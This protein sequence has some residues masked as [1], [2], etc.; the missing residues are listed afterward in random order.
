VQPGVGHPLLVRS[1]GREIPDEHIRNRQDPFGAMGG[2]WMITATHPVLYLVKPHRACHSILPTEDALSPQDRAH[3]H[4]PV[5]LAA[6]LMSF[7]DL[8]QQKRIGCAPSAW[9]SLMSRIAAAPRYPQHLAHWSDL[10]HLLIRFHELL[11]LLP[12]FGKMVMAFFRIS[13]FWVTT[14]RSRLTCLSFACTAARP[15]GSR[16][17]LSEATLYHFRH[18]SSSPVMLPGSRVSSEAFFP[19]LSSKHSASSLNPR[20]HVRYFRVP[21]WTS[22]V[23]CAPFSDIF[24]VHFFVSFRDLCRRKGMK[25]TTGKPTE[26]R[27]PIQMN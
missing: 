23:Q 20:I 13:C 10:K 4:A 6:V 17:W 15:P 5:A 19:Q 2:H 8:Y 1:I 14:A 11:L 3:P 22:F 12:Y 27:Q 9:L 26:R 21:N 7:A 18:F 25:N 24:H 16:L